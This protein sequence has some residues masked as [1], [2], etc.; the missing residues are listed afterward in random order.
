MSTKKIKNISIITIFI[1]PPNLKIL[2]ERLLSRHDGQE[3][4]VGERM[5]KFNEEV[6]HW[7]EYNYVVINDDLNNCFNEICNSVGRISFFPGIH[8]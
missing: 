6:S 5:K 8:P 7:N 2:R 3:K 1:L 4:L